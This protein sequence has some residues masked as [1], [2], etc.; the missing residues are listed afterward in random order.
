MTKNDRDKTATIRIKQVNGRPKRSG[1]GTAGE[2]NPSMPILGAWQA[3]NGTKCEQPDHRGGRR[4]ET[5]LK[6]L[7][8]GSGLRYCSSSCRLRAW[9]L[10]EL[11][12]A[13]HNGTV[14]G[15]RLAFENWREKRS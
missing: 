4:C 15:P 3:V 10:R 12:T 6:A 13:L 9:A 14:D 2:T 7:P 11:T 1:P 5:C 8:P